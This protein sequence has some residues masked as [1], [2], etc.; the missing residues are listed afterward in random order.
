MS[1]IGHQTA[2]EA[3]RAVPKLRDITDFRQL[4]LLW[5]ERHGRRY[6]WRETRDPLS[7]LVAEVMLRRTRADQVTGVYERVI[8]A[9]PDV[10]SL[11]SAPSEE[12]ERM[13]ASLGLRW[14]SPAFKR[15]AEVVR[16]KHGGRVPATRGELLDLPGVGDYVAGAVLSI[17]LG[18]PEWMVDSN[19]VRVFARYFGMVTT[20]EGRRDRHVVETAKA[21]VSC[22]DPR[23]ANLAVV[24]LGALV[25][26]SRNPDCG[27]CPLADGCTHAAGIQV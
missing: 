17:A 9:Y 13:V 14:R 10:R 8:A 23:R 2:G 26:T 25:C 22:E 6:P 24:D 12:I 1:A 20:K 15:L 27:A 3:D 5:F 11:A 7:V 18:K 16:D 19:V 4:L 21:Y